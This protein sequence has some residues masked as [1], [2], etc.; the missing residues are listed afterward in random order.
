MKYIF[1]IFTIFICNLSNSQNK[2]IHF[3]ENTNWEKILVKAKMENKFIFMDCY[4]TWCGPCKGMSNEVF[5]LEEVGDFYNKTFINLKLQLDTT[6]KDD[7]YI[8]SWY[9]IG[10]KIF[11]EYNIVGY[12][13][14][15]FFDPNGKIIHKVF[16]G[17]S[18]EGFIAIGAD[19]INPERQYYNLKQHYENGSRDSA[20]LYNLIKI[21]KSAGEVE[22]YKKVCYEYLTSQK[23]LYTQKN[24]KLLQGAI[25]NSKD[26]GF[27]IMLNYPKRV[28]SISGKGVADAIVNQVI[29]KE[30]VNLEINNKDT[31]DWN[32]LKSKL[33][34]KYPKQAD[35]IIYIAKVNY[36]RRKKD[37][38][39]FGS[40]L[41]NYIRHYENKLPFYQLNEYAFIVFRNCDDKNILKNALQWSKKLLFTNQAK[42]DPDYMD[43]YANLL[44]KLGRKNTAL[45]YIQ[46]AQKI[47]IEQGANKSW[48]Q[49]VIYK[50]KKGEKTW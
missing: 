16:G 15:L 3:E 31:P 46:K 29:V 27:Q 24:I 41:I 25:N 9:A 8:K 13:T 47:A 38:I 37:W 42:I 17:N 45:I 39:A 28:D 35:E 20:F 19:A 21:S 26:F 14:F 23:N 12:P 2:G 50:M 1:I 10:N 43:C 4:T 22:F 44:Y 32:Y 30:E 34:T 5:P 40:T 18:V 36:E 33:K 49:D 7:E 11:K 6:Q 48:G